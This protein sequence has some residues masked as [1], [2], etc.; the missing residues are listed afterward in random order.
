M[1]GNGSSLFGSSGGISAE[2]RAS[3]VATVLPEFIARDG[4]ERADGA[5]KETSTGLVRPAGAAEDMAA[6]L[7]GTRPR[8]TAADKE[9][10]SGNTAGQATGRNGQRSHASECAQARIRRPGRR[11][12]RWKLEWGETRTARLEVTHE[13]AARPRRETRMAGM[14]YTRK[15]II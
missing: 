8:A 6:R 2:T 3:L 13:S 7:D 12:Q 4:Q 9:M 5:I 11:R 1:H 10:K 15:V 14:I